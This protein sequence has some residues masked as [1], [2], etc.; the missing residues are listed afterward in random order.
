[1]LSLTIEK[2]VLLLSH[3]GYAVLF[4]LAVIEGPAVSVL[5]GF[6]VSLGYLNGIA[7]FLVLLLGDVVGDALHYA[8]GRWGRKSFI[9][10]WGKYVG[11]NYERVMK[12][13]E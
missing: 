8:L 13:E 3:Y 10:R 4:P 6:A 12:L 5:A 9:E 1:M 7:V 2:L 11:L